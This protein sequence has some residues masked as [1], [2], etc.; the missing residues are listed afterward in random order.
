MNVVPQLHLHQ[1]TDVLIGQAGDEGGGHGIQ[2]L[3]IALEDG[4]GGGLVHDGTDHGHL[5]L[6]ALVVAVVKGVALPGEAQGLLAV[7]VVDALGE[8]VARHVD[9]VAVSLG[10][11]MPT[12]VNS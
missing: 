3:L 2:H 8:G 9:A 6:A 1:A 5:V 7:E 10:T 11:S 4:R 12:V